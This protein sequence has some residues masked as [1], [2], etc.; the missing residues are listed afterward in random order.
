MEDL[1]SEHERP[2]IT[3]IHRALANPRERPKVY[4]GD[5]LGVAV[6]RTY[7]FRLINECILSRWTAED[8]WHG[9]VVGFVE[10][11]VGCLEEVLIGKIWKFG[12]TLSRRCGIDDNVLLTKIAAVIFVKY[13]S[14]II[15]IPRYNKKILSDVLTL[16]VMESLVLDDLAEAFEEAVWCDQHFSDA[17]R[18][19]SFL[20][21]LNEI[22]AKHKTIPFRAIL[23][24]CPYVMLGKPIFSGF[25][26]GGKD[27][28]LVAGIEVGQ[29]DLVRISRATNGVIFDASKFSYSD[30][31]SYYGGS[32]DGWSEAILE[33]VLS[34]S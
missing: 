8:Q 29:C 1:R 3:C 2:P 4:E 28:G 32:I 15:L 18:A 26:G 14:K 25:V 10:G 34:K 20:D 6:P 9:G 22:R 7:I 11:D 12:V 27:I 24:E 21:P 23:E 19:L 5:E 30:V 17:P 33:Y 31:A 16:S 13:D